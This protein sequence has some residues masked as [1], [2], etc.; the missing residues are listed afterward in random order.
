MSVIKG[1][2]SLTLKWH[3]PNLTGSCIHIPNWKG[4]WCFYCGWG[5]QIQGAFWSGNFWLQSTW[6]EAWKFRTSGWLS[7]LLHSRIIPSTLVSLIRKNIFQSIQHE[8]LAFLVSGGHSTPVMSI[9]SNKSLWWQPSHL[10]LKHVKA[11]F[12]ARV[13]RS[14]NLGPTSRSNFTTLMVSNRQLNTFAK[15]I[16]TLHIPT[17]EC[18]R[19]AKRYCRTN[20]KRTQLAKP[21][22]TCIQYIYILYICMYVQ[23]VSQ[24]FCTLLLKHKR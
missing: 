8:G 17:L 14:F 12:V 13:H 20:H 7:Y 3:F 24:W 21:H 1:L 22:L 4:W 11:L 9:S 15:R 19:T 16:K 5:G 2:H 23:Y 18:K 6:L 10:H